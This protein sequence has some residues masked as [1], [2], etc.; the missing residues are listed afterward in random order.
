MGDVSPIGRTQ[1][2]HF[3]AAVTVLGVVTL[4]CVRWLGLTNGA[5]VATIY[6]MVVLVVAATSHLTTAV[7][8][9]VV[10]TL[11]LNFFFLPPVGTFTI[12]DPQNWVAL[13]A[14]LVV[15]VIASYLSAAAQDRAREAIAPAQRIRA[16]SPSAPGHPPVREHPQVGGRAPMA[17]W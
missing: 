5:A 8:T 17:S 13:F 15:S 1:A 11:A 3:A 14:F 2:W 6:L 10:A 7:A 9:S 16:R 4:A 12:A